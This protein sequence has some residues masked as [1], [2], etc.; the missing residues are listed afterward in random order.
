[1]AYATPDDILNACG[2]RH[3]LI[4]LTDYDGTGE[5]DEG[6][7][8]AA[9][10]S[11]ESWIDSYLRRRYATPLPAPV[12][13]AVA[14]LAAEETKYRLLLR[15]G[16]VTVEETEAHKQRGEWLEKAAKGEVDLGVE[17]A[18][19]KSSS[20][21]AAYASRSE[22]EDISRDSLKGTVW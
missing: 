22:D 17:P 2:G 13:R 9:R 7:R 8:D 10:Q 14:D 21:K 19:S 6:A 18:P 16:M 3:R 5:V 4:E 11:A 15:R 1:M 20:V 12:P